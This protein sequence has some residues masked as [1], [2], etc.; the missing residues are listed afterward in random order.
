M[1]R[2]KINKMIKKP[3]KYPEKSIKTSLN[4]PLLPGTFNCIIS[5]NIPIIKPKAKAKI[6]NSQYLDH[7]NGLKIK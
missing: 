3:N 6:I 1:I 7:L 2:N 4:S 5:V